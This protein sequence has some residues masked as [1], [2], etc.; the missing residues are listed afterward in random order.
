MK[1][2]IYEIRVSKINTTTKTISFDKSFS[3]VVIVEAQDRNSAIDIAIFLVA[4]QTQCQPHLLNVSPSFDI[5]EIS[6][7]HPHVCITNPRPYCYIIPVNKIFLAN[8]FALLLDGQANITRNARFTVDGSIK[9]EIFNG[10]KWFKKTI[11][12]DK[13]KVKTGYEFISAIDTKNE[14]VA[15][16][17]IC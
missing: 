14:L 6:V 17:H 10:E 3:K 1:S 7:T 16:M 15:V 12:K 13:Y 2:H 11:V 8:E 9:F 4:N 5:K